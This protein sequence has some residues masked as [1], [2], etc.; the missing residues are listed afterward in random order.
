MDDHSIFFA[1]ADEIKARPEDAQTITV[2]LNDI[3]FQIPAMPTWLDLQICKDILRR[4]C[5]TGSYARKEYRQFLG[6]FGISIPRSYNN[7]SARAIM[8][9]FS[10]LPASNVA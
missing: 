7:R 1:S 3:D 9:A 8:L 5:I 6:R 4:T 10:Q 2:S